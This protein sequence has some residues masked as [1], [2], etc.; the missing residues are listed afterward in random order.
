MRAA[1]LSL[2]IAL[3]GAALPA[4]APSYALEV[5]RTW[6]VGP[7][8]ELATPSA[9]AAVAG[10]GDTV[11]IDPGTYS[12]D[13]ATWTQDDLTLRGDGGRAHL[14]ADG[15]DAQGKAIWVIAG[16]RTT[17]DRIELSGAS[18][19]DRNGAGIRQEGTDL[20]VTRSWFHDNENGI[21]TGA[22]P[23]SDIVITRLA[24]LPQRLRRRLLPQ[25]LRRRGPLVHRERELARGRRTGHELKS[26]AARNTIVANRISDGD[27]TASYSIDLPNGGRSLVAGNVIVQGPR[28]EN[29]ALV[30]YGAEGLT[31]PSRTLWVVNNTFVNRRT[32]GT[33]VALAAGDARPPAQ[34]PARRA[35]RPHQRAARRR[36]AQ[37][38][39]RPRRLRRPAGGGLP[40]PPVLAGGRPRRRSAPPLAGALGVRR[41]RR[42]CPPT[43]RRPHR[44]RS[45]RA[46]PTRG[47][48]CPA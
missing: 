29:P 13:V 4:V 38:C 45:A 10:D 25:P 41:S 18:V 26:R 35:G 23:E 6:R 9:A 37:P 19:P 39:R 8:R 32:S 28:S 11:L 22:D 47:L 33:F 30:S 24:V 14:R 27:A 46:P 17:V 15:N 42:P 16:D 1:V 5:P 7:D 48:V 20:T 12:G 34:Q 43:G 21:L 44:P 3:A 40:P 31:H 36:A 2:A